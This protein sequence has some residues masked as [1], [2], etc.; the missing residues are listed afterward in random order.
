MVDLGYNWK[1]ITYYR[2]H[3]IIR[4][5]TDLIVYLGYLP[6]VLR[7]ALSSVVPRKASSC[8][9]GR[10]GGAAH[11]VC[12]GYPGSYP[13]QLVPERLVPVEQRRLEQVLA[14]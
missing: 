9:L 8:G 4:I 14:V 2:N 6:S 13:P 5:L 12:R 10:S 7:E 1:V 11:M 3:G